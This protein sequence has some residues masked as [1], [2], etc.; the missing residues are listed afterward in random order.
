MKDQEELCKE[1]SNLLTNLCMKEG[2]ND[3]K[4]LILAQKCEEIE[5]RLLE[6]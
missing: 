3:E 2:E 6:V 1:S 5:A 4:M